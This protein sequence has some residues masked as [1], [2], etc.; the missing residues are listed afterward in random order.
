VHQSRCL[1]Y[2][3]VL[4][5]K[6]GQPESVRQ[7]ASRILNAAT[8]GQMV[9]YIGMARA[10]LAWAAW[11]EGNLAQAETEGQAALE[12]WQQLPV[13]HS[14]CAFQW[15]A[16]WPGVAVAF[17]RNWIS[18]ASKFAHAL[19]EPT[20]QCLPDDL[21]AVVQNAVKAWKGDESKSARTYLA[22]ALELA[23]ELGYL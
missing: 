1:T 19:L 23:Q 6:R 8:A 5:R 22:Q 13:G 7:L 21:T 20:Q 17:A 18:E 4:Y 12:L 14:S 9:E 10:N 3:T 2:L 15:T 16:L 11:H